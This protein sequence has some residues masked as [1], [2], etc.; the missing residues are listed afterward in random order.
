MKL[1][2]EII[3]KSQNDFQV[4]FK[5]FEKDALEF[6]KENE[7]AVIVCDY[8]LESQTGPQLI[9]MAKERV[10]SLR[11]IVMSGEDI[12]SIRAACEEAGVDLILSKG[13]LHQTLIP[14][15]KKLLET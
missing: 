15:I 9:K 12:Q 1:A 2:L 8:N 4:I 11:T 6:V 10:P 13:N 3:L 7:I 5:Q 14:A